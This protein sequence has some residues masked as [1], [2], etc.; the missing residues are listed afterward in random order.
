MRYLR[1]HTMDPK[2]API[3]ALR[4]AI[5]ETQ[6]APLDLMMMI[7]RIETRTGGAETD[8]GATGQMEAGLHKLYVRLMVAM[9][10]LRSSSRISASSNGTSPTPSTWQRMSG[11]GG[12]LLSIVPGEMTN[13]RVSASAAKNR[14]TRR[15]RSGLVSP[16]GMRSGEAHGSFGGGYSRE[17]FWRRNF[18]TGSTIECLAHRRL[19]GPSRAHQPHT[20]TGDTEV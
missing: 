10:S 11:S 3:E 14:N 17:D 19:S 9:T 4:A 20:K 16:G 5:A 7:D 15:S 1:G 12:T 13:P 2:K 6:G 8:S 18:N